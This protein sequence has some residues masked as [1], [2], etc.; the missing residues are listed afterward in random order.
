MMPLI[1]THQIT[2]ALI[3]T[4]IHLNVEQKTLPVVYLAMMPVVFATD[5][6]I[7][8]GKSNSSSGHQFK[9]ILSTKHTCSSSLLLSASLTLFY[10]MLC[11]QLKEN[12]S[13]QIPA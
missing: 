4:L 9:K 1:L 10:L 13:T 11:Q 8:L 6:A 5:T 3:T 7:V 2:L 12:P